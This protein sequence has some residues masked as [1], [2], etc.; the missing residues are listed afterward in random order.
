MNQA[1]LA[2]CHHQ[3]HDSLQAGLTRLIKTQWA[4]TWLEVRMDELGLV[5]SLQ[6]APDQMNIYVIHT[7]I[8]LESLLTSN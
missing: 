6:L 2:I 5:P 4:N 3:G 1:G 7:T 8:F